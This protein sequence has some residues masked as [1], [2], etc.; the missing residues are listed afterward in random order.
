MDD[1]LTF[2]WGKHARESYYI[3]STLE[4]ILINVHDNYITNYFN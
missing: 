3:Y 2:L 4:L 1:Q